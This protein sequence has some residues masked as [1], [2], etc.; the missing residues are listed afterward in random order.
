MTYFEFDEYGWIISHIDNPNGSLIYGYYSQVDERDNIWF[1]QDPPTVKQREALHTS[2]HR[3]DF[4]ECK[5]KALQALIEY[6]I[7]IIQRIK[8]EIVQCEY[9]IEGKGEE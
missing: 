2:V 9:E 4:Y 1:M 8:K 3:E 7:D 6:K 5:T